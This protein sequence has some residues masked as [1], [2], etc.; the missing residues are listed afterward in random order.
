MKC[1]L[2]PAVERR[3]EDIVLNSRFISIVSP[4]FNVEQARHFIS[5]IKK[6]Y[7]DATHHVTAYIIG[8]GSS[9]I[10]HCSDAGEP[11]GTAGRPA[12]AVLSGSG[13][14]DVAVVITRYYGGTKLGTG[15]LVRA[16]SDAVR[17]VL[18]GLPR[19]QKVLTHTILLS[20]PYSWYERLQMII[21]N[22]N[23][24]ILE[25]DFATEITYTI[26]LPVDCYAAFQTYLSDASQGSL[27]A[28]IINTEETILPLDQK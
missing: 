3:F 6:E 23:G 19:A 16:Y 24:R 25:Q 20:V 26:Q 15:G 28:V 10:S 12:L 13:L 7:P 4:V 18:D 17:Q 1:Y 22:H 27:Q 2:I 11:A 5:R 21:L 8:F 9:I 14:G